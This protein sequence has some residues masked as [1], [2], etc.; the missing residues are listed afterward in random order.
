MKT[1][2]CKLCG[3]KGR[4]HIHH[5]IPLSRYGSEELENIIELC[6]N[7]H[8]EATEDLERFNIRF[9]LKGK[10]KSKEELEALSE[11]T[12]LY[13]GQVNGIGI[14]E[15]K[16]NFLQ[17]KYNFDKVD[18]VSFAMGITRRRVIENYLDPKDK[19]IRKE[20]KGGNTQ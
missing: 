9:N 17:K 15:E 16:L 14:D 8:A 20:S 4:T 10:R 19:Q 11:F 2:T 13:M 3:W 5:I 1:Y 18:A 6:P 7:H 12:I